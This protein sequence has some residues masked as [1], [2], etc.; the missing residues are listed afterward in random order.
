[1]GTRVSVESFSLSAAEDQ[2]RRLCAT[3]GEA[4]PVRTSVPRLDPLVR[5]ESPDRFRGLGGANLLALVELEPSVAEPL[6][7]PAEWS[8]WKNGTLPG[9]MA[10]KRPVASPIWSCGTMSGIM[11]G[12]RPAR[13]CPV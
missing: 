3:H 1:M 6:S 4:A 2:L 7:A 10:G 8:V 11:A 13:N 9:V 5:D 12:K